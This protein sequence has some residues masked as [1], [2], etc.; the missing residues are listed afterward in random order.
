M[1]SW[2]NT[3]FET[4]TRIIHCIAKFC[5]YGGRK[6]VFENSVPTYGGVIVREKIDPTEDKIPKEPFY[7]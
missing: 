1:N 3:N 7:G 2:S 5:S 6:C 4:P